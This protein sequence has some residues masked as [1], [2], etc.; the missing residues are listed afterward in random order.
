MPD[1]MKTLVV[2]LS[3]L[4]DLFH[5]L[6]A[7]NQL[8]EGLDCEI[9]WVTQKEY[10]GVV[11]CFKDVDKVIEFSRREPAKSG[12]FLNELRAERYDLV[13]DMQGLL[14]SAVITGFSR[15]RR[16]I[17]PS[18]R[19][20][21]S[22]IFYG[23]IAGRRNKE[24]HAVEENMDFVS[25]LGLEHKN[26]RFFPV[27]FPDVEISGTRPR[28]AILPRSRWSTKNWPLEYYVQVAGYLQ[29]TLYATIFLSGADADRPACERIA[30]QLPR[31]AVNVAGM[32]SLPEVGGFLARMDLL[33]AN[34]SGP[35]HMAAAAGT[36]AAVPFGPTSAERTGPYGQGHTAFCSAESC[37]P[38]FSRQCKR[39]G[40]PCLWGIKP[41]EV[42]KAAVAILKKT[43]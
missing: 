38:C 7:L 12:V 34:D 40:M 15:G 10:A 25:H 35:V 43:Y 16:K 27:E 17:G 6:P 4:G 36:P 30:Q 9:T 19:R 20:E 3:S 42:Q 18:F 32:H 21:C 23:E 41:E 28:V 29:E 39:G 13:L 2:K 5:A 33:I 37:S 8:K 1:L 24:R 22:G 11:R 14:K 31:E 26:N